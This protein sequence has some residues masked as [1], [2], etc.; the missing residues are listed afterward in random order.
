MTL[1]EA[2]VRSKKIL[3]QA[4]ITSADLDAEVILM[5]LLKKDKDFIFTH[6]EA[7]LTAVQEKKY[8]QDIKKRFKGLPVAYITG[9]KEFYGLKFKVDR[10]VLIPRPETE[11]LA[12]E[13]INIAKKIS[14]KNP[15][16]VDIG[17]GS[18]A[19]AISIAKNLPGVKTIATDKSSKA[20][21]IARKNA[22]LN[23]AKI[24]FK[25][26]NLLKPILNTKVNI[27]IANLPYLETNYK[28]S[29][30]KYE[31]KLALYS[32]KDGLDSYR[33]LIKQLS[34]LKNLP[35]YILLE[36]GAKQFKKLTSIIKKSFPQA[37][38]RVEKD[39]AGFDRYLV[40]G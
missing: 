20:L 12:E 1:K 19:I 3:A 39:L 17:T 29:S 7:K 33:E 21:E 40:W 6:P 26:G 28:N 5:S 14:T 11:L 16:I 24:I 34:Q 15:T 37:K 13:A 36:A 32:G 10:H 22:R 35:E 4:K 23:K 38:I 31:P 18:G 30:I 2:L 25:K 8:L 27:L 9:E